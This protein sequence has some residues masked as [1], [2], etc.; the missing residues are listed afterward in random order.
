MHCT[1]QP[2]SSA[3]SL[4]APPPQTTPEGT[5]AVPPPHMGPETIGLNTA[6]TLCAQ[7]STTRCRIILYGIKGAAG[8]DADV[9][10][11]VGLLACPPDRSRLLR[12]ACR[13]CSRGPDWRAA[14]VGAARH[15]SAILIKARPS[16]TAAA[17]P[18]P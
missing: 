8:G 2:S 15:P 7:D 9:A 14:V 11:S 10:G 1:A 16:W 12:A 18:C 3:A 6:I 13:P 5:S 17:R 4:T